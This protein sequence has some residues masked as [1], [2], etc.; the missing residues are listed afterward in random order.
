MRLRELLWLTCTLTALATQANTVRLLIAGDIMLDDG[1]GK[2]IAA[3]G[4]PLAP[5]DAFLRDADYRIA[6]LE[7]PIATVGKGLENKIF[8]FRAHPRVVEKLKGRFDALALANNHSG[9]YGRDAF[10]ETIQHIRAGGIAHF[11][12]GR[13]LAEAHKPLWVERKG[14]RIALLSYNEFK[15]RS[16]EAGANQPGIAWSEDSH[17]VQDIEAA[18]AAGADIVIPFMHWGWEHETEPNSRQQQL[19]QLMIDAGADAVVGGHPH[20]TQGATLYRGKP[21]IWSLGNFVFDGFTE[22]P[23]RIGWL[24]RLELDKQGVQRWD[25]ITAHMD[26]AGTPR[27]LLN[28]PSPC[29]ERGKEGIQNCLNTQTD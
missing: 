27:P 20:V 4:D 6:N 12:G 3:G 26:D 25:T 15:P 2:T 29:G 1:P 10:Q 28:H 19:A 9:D 18:R 17:V 11:G 22:G 13:N 24:L 16:F 21:I 14:L 5:F 8:T 7:C 23:G